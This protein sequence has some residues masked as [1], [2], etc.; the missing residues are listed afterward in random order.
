[1]TAVPPQLSAL[2]C[3]AMAV[4]DL[5]GET[6]P[7]QIAMDLEL[8]LPIS[9]ASRTKNI[10]VSLQPHRPPHGCGANAV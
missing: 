4:S 2:R 5:R 9:L 1:M 7:V 10:V 6:G 8:S 3:A